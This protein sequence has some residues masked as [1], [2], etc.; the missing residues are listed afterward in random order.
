MKIGIDARFLTHPQPGGFKTYVESLVAALAQLDTEN[1]YVL[2]V[3][4]RPNDGCR[5]PAGSNFVSRV[6]PGSLPVIGMPWREQ[7]GLASQ[8]ARD[9]IDLFHAP[10]LTAPLYLDCPLVVTVHDMIWAFPERFAH[11]GSRSIKRQL[12]GW[13]NYAV[14]KSVLKRA[15]AIITVSRASKKSIVAHSGLGD[16]RIFVTYEAA[17]PSFEQIKEGQR[18]EAGRRKYGLPIDFILAI[19]SADPRKNI[20]TLVQAYS[21]L[22]QGLQEKHQLVIVW[23]HPL[24]ADELSKEIE[25]LGLVNRV[26]FLRHVSTDDLV[27]LYNAASLFVFPSLYEGFGLPPLEAMA[28]GVPVIAADNS[29]IPEIVGDAALLFNAN[30]AQMLSASITQVLKDE[31]AKERLIQNGLIQTARFSWEKCADQTIAVYENT[32]ARTRQ[33]K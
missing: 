21:M 29:S 28:C 1:E 13:Y 7:I 2:Y 3:D 9:R 27:L 33:G 16:D 12:M 8:V 26:R 31:S 5:L 15:S 10:C 4:R 14:P 30:D 17:S 23:T 32:W 22:P 20:N 11:V 6:V 24:L 18:I 19:G 25:G